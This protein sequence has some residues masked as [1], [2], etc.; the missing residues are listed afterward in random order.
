MEKKEKIDYDEKYFNTN[1]LFSTKYDSLFRDVVKKRGISYYSIHRVTNFRQ[2]K[3]KISAVVKGTKDYN[4]S[5]KYLD[6]DKIKVRCECPYHKDTDPYC[7]HVYALILNLKMLYEKEKMINIYKI[8]C[9]KIID[10]E[11]EINTLVTNNKKY[12]DDEIYSD[13]LKLQDKYDEYLKIMEERFDYSDDISLI[14]SVHSSYFWLNSIIDAY[15]EII[16]W[17]NLYKKRL[18]EENNPHI[19]TYS[20]TIDNSAIFNSI[21]NILANVDTSILEKV[22]QDNIKN[23]KSTEIVD[24]A[25]SQRKNAKVQKKYRKNTFFGLLSRLFDDSSSK[26]CSNKD[27]LMPWEQDYVNKGEYEPY[28]FEEEELE[29]DDYYEDE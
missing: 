5:I 17:I 19:T 11:E 6:N 14:N 21:D 2:T 4:V 9:Q 27:Y 16:D 22:R 26:S 29:E 1:N 24:K 12:L 8:N 23:G 25:I 13:S 20:F 18:E 7:K 3:N 15:N 10:I 28:Q